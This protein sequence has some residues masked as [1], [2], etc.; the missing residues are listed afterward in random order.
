MA[1]PQADALLFF[2]A[3]RSGL[4]VDLP[5][6][7]GDDP[8]RSSRRTCHRRRQGGLEIGESIF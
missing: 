7:A 6:A 5:S 2:G 3:R 1:E 4:Q 8:A